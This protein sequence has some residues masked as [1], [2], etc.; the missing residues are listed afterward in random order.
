MSHIGRST[1]KHLGFLGFQD[2]WRNSARPSVYRNEAALL[3][4]LLM[5]LVDEQ[6]IDL[7]ALCDRHGTGAELDFGTHQESSFEGVAE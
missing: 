7:G 3:L 1:E 2:L 5:D 4:G 6:E